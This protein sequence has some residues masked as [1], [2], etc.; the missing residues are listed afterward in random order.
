MRGNICFDFFFSLRN[1]SIYILIVTRL[2]KISNK[3]LEKYNE[4][5]F[6]KKPIFKNLAIISWKHLC[7]SLFFNENAGIQSCNLIKKRL[8]QWSFP[9]NFLELL[10]TPILKNISER[11]FERFPTWINNIKSNKWRKI[12]SQNRKQQKQQRQKF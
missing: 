2:F 1:H 7:W 3:I 12:F 10:K 5:V 6:C 4:Q 9:V 8:Q 11:L